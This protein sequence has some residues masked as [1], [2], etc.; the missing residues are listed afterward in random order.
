VGEELRSVASMLVLTLLIFSLI[1]KAASVTPNGELNITKLSSEIPDPSSFSNVTIHEGDLIVGNSTELLIENCLFNVTGNLRISEKARVV[2]RNASLVLNWNASQ[3]LERTGWRTR[4]IVVENNSRLEVSECDI[5]LTGEGLATEYCGFLLFDQAFVNLTLTNF[6]HKWGKGEVIYLYG[7][8][9][10]E[11]NHV[12]LSTIGSNQW[13]QMVKSWILGYNKVD[14]HSRSSIIDGIEFFGNCTAD[15][16]SLEVEF[17]QTDHSDCSQIKV[18]DSKIKEL[19]TGIGTASSIWLENC[20]IG[21][22]Q[23]LGN[24]QTWLHNSLEVENYYSND[25]KVFIVW[26]LPFIGQLSIPYL[27][28]PFII[29]IIVTIIMSVVIL[30][31]VIKYL[32]TKR[33]SMVDIQESV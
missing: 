13:G 19:K 29:P 10:L 4:H 26:D 31:F 33:K 12:K 22:L 25:G 5:I 1:S 20:T 7:A 18:Y 6:T 27:W 17:F 14:I 11:M 23:I 9:T 28:A 2:I 30:L 32:R 16:Y 15:L 21:T 8:S 24:S 3:P